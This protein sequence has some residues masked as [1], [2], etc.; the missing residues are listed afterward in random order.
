MNGLDGGQMMPKGKGKTRTYR[1]FV[2]RECVPKKGWAVRD[3]FEVGFGQCNFCG[4]VTRDL[5]ETPLL[6]VE[7]K[8]KRKKV[9]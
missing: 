3:L 9:G 5:L 4:C 1:V 2:C 8:E 7:T 6:V